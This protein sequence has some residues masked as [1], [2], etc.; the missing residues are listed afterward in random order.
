[1]PVE[2]KLQTTKPVLICNR[3]LC[4]RGKA[5]TSGCGDN[6]QGIQ[7]R[8]CWFRLERQV[9]E[10][11]KQRYFVW[12]QCWRGGSQAGVWAIVVGASCFVGGEVMSSTYECV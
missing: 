7:D 5:R 6:L 9:K 8:S 10:R 2:V 1:M 4:S 11:V 3:A 12:I